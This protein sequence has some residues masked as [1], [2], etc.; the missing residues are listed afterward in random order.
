[1]P[2]PYSPAVKLRR[3]QTFTNIEPTA[4]AKQM[5]A[6]AVGL[7]RAIFVCASFGSRSQHFQ[8]ITLSLRKYSGLVRVGKITRLPAGT[9]DIEI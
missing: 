1:M 3:P 5:R 6:F 2:M 7:C 8:L 9:S 4:A